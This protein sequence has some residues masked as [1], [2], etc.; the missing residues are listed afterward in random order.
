MYRET[1]LMELFTVSKN[2]LFTKFLGDAE[3]AD[4]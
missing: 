3:L 2:L 1:V 4:A